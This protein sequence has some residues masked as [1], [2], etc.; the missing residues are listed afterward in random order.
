MRV[1]LAILLLS[2]FSVAMHGQ[3][4]QGSRATLTVVPWAPRLS[5]VKPLLDESFEYAAAVNEIARAFDLRG[6]TTVSFVEKYRAANLKDIIN[7]DEW[8]TEFK[9]VMDDIPA[10][11]MVQVRLDLVEGKYGN[12]LNAILEVI[13]KSSQLSIMNSGVIESPPRSTPNYASMIKYMLRDQE[14]GFPAFMNELGTKFSEIRRDGAAV[15]LS[16]GVD[17]N[18]AYDLETFVGDEGYLLGEKI[19]AWVLATSTKWYEAGLITD[20]SYRLASSDASALVYDNVRVPFTKP[21]GSRYDTNM[22]GTELRLAVSKMGKAS[23]KGSFFRV[24]VETG[25]NQI[26]VT[27]LE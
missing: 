12:S 22:F 24:R 2:L 6:F 25:R 13:D 20:I 11:I 27:I 5:D 9:R 21:D 15:Q 17:E 23:E 7:L 1:P 26:F 14:G 18:C 4:G 10:D 3:S 16:I 19:T 8:E